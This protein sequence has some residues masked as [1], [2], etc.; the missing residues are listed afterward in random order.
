MIG[1][2]DSLPLV[3][4]DNAALGD[5]VPVVNIVGRHRVRDACKIPLESVQTAHD[6]QEGTEN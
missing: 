2:V 5:I 3:N 1:G 4:H 6:V